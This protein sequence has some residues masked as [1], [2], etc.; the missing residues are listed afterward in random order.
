MLARLALRSALGFTVFHTSVLDVAIIHRLRKSI[1]QVE[2]VLGHSDRAQQ[3]VLN[4]TV[5]VI[6]IKVVQ[7]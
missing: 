7:K 2:Q 1:S 6:V 4:R 5:L 3:L